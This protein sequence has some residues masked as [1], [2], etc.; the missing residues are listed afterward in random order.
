VNL[1]WLKKSF[2]L[3]SVALINISI[4][5]TESPILS[6]EFTGNEAISG[7]ALDKKLTSFIGKPI[8]Q[9]RLE[10]IRVTVF[11][12]Y[13]NKGYLSRVE[14]P[15]QDLSE[16]IV[17]LRI[18]EVGLG[19]VTVQAPEDLRF[20]KARAEQ[21]IQSPLTG[22]KPLSVELLDESAKVL[23]SLAGI[24]AEAKIIPGGVGEEVDLNLVMENTDFSEVSLQTDNLGAESTG[25]HRYT[26]DL[27][28]NSA[29]NLGEKTVFSAVKSKGLQSLSIDLE[30][31]VGIEGAKGVIGAE[32]STYDVDIDS[33]SAVDGES[34][35]YWLRYRFPTS[36]LLEMPF[37][38]E[39][40]FEHAKTE[41]DLMPTA[42]PLNNKTNKK[43]YANGSVS[44]INDAASTAANISLK[45]TAGD[46][47]L[48]AISTVFDADQAGA[49][50]DG[51]YLKLNLDISG[52][53]KLT[54]TDSMTFTSS[55]QVANKNF[56]G[57]DE[58]ELSGPTGVR[59]Y[60]VGAVSVDMGCFAQNEFVRQLSQEIAGFVFADIGYGQTH[61]N[62]YANWQ[63]ASEKNTFGIAGVGLGVRMAPRDNVNLSFTYARR[64][65]SCD[66][67]SDPQDSGKAWAVATV[68]F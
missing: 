18:I 14:L 19:K 68:T 37:N 15:A 11:D 38:A 5:A 67:C 13:S 66:G 17:R 7:E 16:G 27:Q 8:T 23:D 10:N 22:I 31:P 42:T 34:P 20:S 36:Q 64:V 6:I 47:D 55:C 53:K 12:A 1:N 21:F 51:K 61:K 54:P 3:I 28:L 41:D 57:A 33:G 2:A 39:I 24:S 30:V 45:L 25:R 60:D 50:T 49:K 29:M 32:R 62:T 65:G 26:A 4:A 43:I 56:D 52:Q 48:S 63:T 58:I 35:K 44:W 40:G 9:E 46:L 59:A